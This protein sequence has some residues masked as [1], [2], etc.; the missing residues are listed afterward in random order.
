MVLLET[1]IEVATR[2]KLVIFARTKRETLFLH[3]IIMFY[4]LGLM[5]GVEINHLILQSIGQ[6][7]SQDSLTSL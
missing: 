3:A 1:E 2:R 6:R 7:T 4:G 5:E